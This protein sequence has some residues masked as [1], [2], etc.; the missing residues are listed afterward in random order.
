MSRQEKE[1]MSFHGHSTSTSAPAWVC[2]P[3]QRCQHRQLH[4]YLL[5]LFLSDHLD[6]PHVLGLS[7][8]HEIFYKQMSVNVGL[9]WNVHK[10]LGYTSEQDEN[11][12]YQHVGLRYSF[13]FSRN[14]LYLGFQIK[15]HRFGKV[16]CVQ[17]ISG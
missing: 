6:C 14:R 3:Y 15:A 7:Q 4:E 17:L 11:W 2:V 10:R 8:R 1:K 5:G 9:G 16:D 13:P 12:F